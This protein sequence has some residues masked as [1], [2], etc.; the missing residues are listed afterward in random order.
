[1]AYMRHENRT[2]A[3]SGPLLI[4][5]FIRLEREPQLG[6]GFVLSKQLHHIRVGHGSAR[7]LLLLLLLLLRTLLFVLEL[8]VR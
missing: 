4:F 2:V 5:G 6:T 3:I 8:C 7:I 1:M